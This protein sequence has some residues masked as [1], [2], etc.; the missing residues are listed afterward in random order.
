MFINIKTL[1]KENK[2]PILV[3]M[4][5]ALTVIIY[6][7][8][9]GFYYPKIDLLI[10]SSKQDEVQIF[11]NKGNG[12]SEQ[13]S[14]IKI[15]HTDM[16]TQLEFKIANSDKIRMDF[17]STGSRVQVLGAKL[18]NGEVE[19]NLISNIQH[20][21][22]HDANLIDYGNNTLCV[23]ASG[24]DP[25][26]ILDGDFSGYTIYNGYKVLIKY[27]FIFAFVFT[28]SYLSIML[29]RC[30]RKL[31]LITLIGILIR[32]LYFLNS[33]LPTDFN[34]LYLFYPDEGNYYFNY[35]FKLLHDGVINYFN[36]QSS[37]EVAPGNILYLSVLLKIFNFNIAIVRLFNIVSLSGIT[38]V[39]T[40]FIAER[41]FGSKAAVIASSLVALYPELICFAPTILTEP[42]FLALFI[43]FLFLLDQV[44]QKS[45]ITKT[46]IFYI[47]TCAVVGVMASLTRVVFLP[48]YL[49]LL[50][51]AIYMYKM[52]Y[53]L[54]AFKIFIL[55]SISTALILPFLVNGYVHSGKIMISTG[56]G[57]VL[58][59]GSRIDTDGDE[60]PYHHKTYDTELITKGASHISLEGDQRLKEAGLANIKAHP[61]NYAFMCVKRIGRLAVGNKY[62]WFLPYSNFLDWYHNHTLL[63]SIVKLFSL[64][65]AILVFVFG[66]FGAFLFGRNISI[67]HVV[68]LMLFMIVIYL[69]FLVNQRYGLPVFLINAILTGGLLSIDKKLVVQKIFLLSVTILIAGFIIAGI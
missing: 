26:I 59:L 1:F 39:F 58:W 35:A 18:V 33:G 38:I 10:E 55:I 28:L 40:Y 53:K 52:N 8:I 36:S 25:Y 64:F 56:S 46:H 61:I 27:L 14:I 62:F 66:I 30:N 11:M 24:I 17:G 23:Q 49:V 15:I 3:S 57:A 5:I 50:L 65:V 43:V 2:F 6:M 47:L 32:W 60:P 22:L 7:H 41:H 68:L 48:F 16:P 29:S 45:A 63:E 12:F 9:T 42:L 4:I 21:Y 34:G 44:F 31:F 54:S 13:D 37:I 20:G 67:L 69:P 51:L 19:K